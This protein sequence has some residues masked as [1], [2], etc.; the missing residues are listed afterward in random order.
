MAGVGVPQVTAIHDCA[1]AAAAARASRSSPTV[2]SSYSGDIAKAIAAGAD[3][4]MLGWLLAGVDES[5]GEVVLH[6][7]ERY[8]EYRGH[9]LARAP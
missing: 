3:V 2:A 9:G 5:P 6:Q 8:K 4:V 1:V 7:G